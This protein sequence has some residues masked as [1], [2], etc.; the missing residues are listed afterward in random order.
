MTGQTHPPGAPPLPTPRPAGPP[1][2]PGRK[3][4]TPI[5]PE[6]P[7]GRAAADA[8]SQVLAEILVA[9]WHRRAA[10]EQGVA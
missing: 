6:S 2:G 5:D 4:V 8:L 10:R 3:V 7:G 9:K 1:T